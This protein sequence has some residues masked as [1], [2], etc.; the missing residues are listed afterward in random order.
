MVL[1]ST[2]EV[3]RADETW[4]WSR[5]FGKNLRPRAVGRVVNRIA[6][7]VSAIALVALTVALLPDRR[8]VGWSLDD[9]IPI[10]VYDPVRAGQP[11]P[12]GFR[13]LLPRDAIPPIYDPNFV[14]ADESP[15]DGDV[16]VIGVAQDGEAKAY[17][18][19]WLNRREMVID[20]IADEPILVSW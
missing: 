16:D 5:R 17:P 2:P 7:V 19:S 3:R 1:P 9:P 11:T 18:V 14:A 8:E 12:P 10:D 6:L 15:W 13:Q 4:A 20:F